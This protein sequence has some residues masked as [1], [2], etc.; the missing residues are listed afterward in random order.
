[1]QKLKY[2]LLSILLLGQVAA[3]VAA[4][5]DFRTLSVNDGLSQNTVLALSEDPLGRMWMGTQ[6]GLNRYDGYSFTLFRHDENDP[7]S[8]GDNFINSLLSD[9]G[10][11]WIGTSVGLSCYDAATDSFENFYLEGRPMQVFDIV[12]CD[13]CLLLATDLGVVI[14]DR[15]THKIEI[16]V[17]MK[18][19]VVRTIHPAGMG[20]L[21]GT[22]EGVYNFS[23]AYGTMERILPQMARADVVSIISDDEGFWIGTHG[24]GLFR[25]NNERRVVA[26]YTTADSP[27]LVSDYVRILKIDDH[28]RLWVGTFDGLSLRDPLTGAFEPYVHTR[29][30]GSLSHNS[31]RSMFIDRQQGVWLGTYYGGVSYYHPL[32]RRFFAERHLQSGNTMVDNTVDCVSEDDDHNL[33]IGTN[34]NGLN[35]Y[36]A[37]TWRFENF[38]VGNR[39]LLSNNIKS[40]LPDHGKLWI[41]TH[42]GGLSCLDV[43]SRQVRHFPINANIPINNSCYALMKDEDEG[44]WVGSL[45]GLL[46]FDIRTGRFTSHPVTK[47]EP[48]LKSLQINYLRRDSKHRVWIG[49]PS[50]LYLYQPES[51]EVLSLNLNATLGEG[52]GIPYEVAVMSI[53]EDSRHNIWIGTRQGLYRYKEAEKKFDRYTVRDGLPNN[54]V[55]GILEDELSRLW[56]STNGGLSCFNVE[57]DIF[58]NYTVRD[59]IANSQFNPYAYFKGHD[60][61][62]YFGG[63]GGLTCFR[64]HELVDNPFTPQ[65][66]I[67]DVRVLDADRHTRITRDDYGRV[68]RAEFPFRRNIFTVDF[69]V[70]NPLSDG[71]NTY[72]YCLEGFNNR[73]YETSNREV[74]YSNLSPGTYRFR[75]RAANNDG[76]WNNEE[77]VTEIC[78][79]PMWW[80]TLA[81]R[82]LWVLLVIGVLGAMI[83]AVLWRL[84]MKMQLRLE[85]MEKQQI[86]DLS[87]EKIRFYINLSH[88]LRTPL[89]LIMSP[90]QEIREHGM[91]DKYVASRLNYIYRNSL[92]LLH[93]VNQLIDYRKAEQGVFRM[94]VAMQ[95][96]DAIVGEVF[97]M[98]EDR[99]QN[100]DMDYI[101][102]SDLKGE[103]LPVDR[104][105]I[106]MILTNLLSNAF[107]FTPNG[108]IIRVSLQ[109]GVGSFSLTV[110]DNGVGMSPELQRHAFDRFY[111]KE[112]GP[113]SGGLGLSIVHRIVEMHEGTITLDSEEGKFCEFVVTLPDSME[114]YPREKHAREDD[115]RGSI[116]RDAVLPDEWSSDEE[117]VELVHDTIDTEEKHEVILLVE[118]NAEVSHYIAEHF[119]S[120]YEVKI[121]SDGN[122]ALERLKDIEPDL[123]IADRMLPGM[124]GLRLCQAIKQNIRTCHIPVILLAPDGGVEEQITGIEAG[125]DGYL[126][127][128]LSV[129]LLRAKVQNLLKARYRMRHHY[130]DDA[131]ID[132]EKIT[133]NSMDGE[134]LKK[135]IRIVEENMDNEEFSSNDFSK[136][137]CMSRSNLHLKMKSI[138]G[139]SATKFIRKIRFNY[140]CRLLL[141]RKH[142]IAEISSM[143][144][145]NSPSYFA[146]S[147]KKHVG[148]L[149]TEYLRN[150][151]KTDSVEL[152]APKPEGK[153]P[154][155]GAKSAKA[156]SE[157]PEEDLLLTQGAGIV[158]SDGG[159]WE[160]EAADRGS[161][162]ASGVEKTSRSNSEDKASGRGLTRKSA[163]KESAS[164]RRTTRTTT[165]RKAAEV[166]AGEIAPAVS[167]KRGG[168]ISARK[169][170]GDSAPVD[171][172]SAL[173]PEHPESGE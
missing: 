133:S 123:V 116:I 134:F 90:L 60:G 31:I 32:A 3:S 57:K 166:D 59:G 79:L 81:A 42:A 135:A 110:R 72:S 146:T 52:S 138:T 39:K 168:K 157:N 109:R 89:T 9:G 56:I 62:F 145:F 173:A 74:T 25:L 63:I 144:G 35:F 106:E 102:S 71:H 61:M 155:R 147:F 41:G 149:P 152:A 22:S 127:M 154:H 23:L 55:Y 105:F 47:L 11:M 44:L 69:A 153:R 94:R 136:A 150:R 73:W 83:W 80:Q 140:A 170:S 167:P 164:N 92:K 143:V 120:R 8:L 159:S 34:D 108:G 165:S 131:E 100:R 16:K 21:V 4:S 104:M 82:I 160:E 33:W 40:L 7:G 53:M 24:D 19:V 119:N 29:R 151:S 98:F 45:N 142:S 121:V 103:L 20:F 163:G 114:A 6:D 125:A 97:S 171:A 162:K 14:F 17:F 124:D 28:K 36:E 137:L 158:D 27:G 66:Q 128:P 78:V 113:T 87:Q 68:V 77:V 132:P 85:R 148:C 70:M 139:E 12:P 99:A 54:I 122:D 5:L 58:R 126:P 75:V 141:E 130:S 64:P 96:V 111:R 76:R 107:K 88:E 172:E 65:P 156:E 67:L 18:N 51:R 48:R 10:R 112:D 43:A 84:K 13:T 91:V 46:L 30:E 49:T 86:G 161:E 38:S 169:T 26:H 2:I 50:G 93:L 1:M 37:R 129:S 118:A 117:V 115:L 15:A 95:D 101:L